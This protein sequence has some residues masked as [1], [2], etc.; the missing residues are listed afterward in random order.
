MSTAYPQAVSTMTVTLTLTVAKKGSTFS[1]IY[2]NS[3]SSFRLKARNYPSLTYGYQSINLVKNITWKKP[4]Q[5]KTYQSAFSDT[6]AT[7]NDY[8]IFPHLIRYNAESNFESSSYRRKPH[9]LHDMTTSEKNN[10]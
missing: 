9:T 8:F 10:I 3:I 5:K 4:E 1:L 2:D 7:Q 6:A